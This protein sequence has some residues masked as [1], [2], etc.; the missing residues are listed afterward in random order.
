M[1]FPRVGLIIAMLVSLSGCSSQVQKETLV[2]DYA[3]FGPQAMAYR[4]IGPKNLPWQP[5]TPLLIGQGNVLIVVYKDIEL[6]EVKRSYQPDQR[7]LID[8]RYLPYTEALDYLDARISQN[9]LHK[10]TTRLQETRKT[11]TQQWR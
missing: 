9:L 7:E 5:D 4:A 6:D 10:V 8:Y 11:I 3:D 1:A 2:F